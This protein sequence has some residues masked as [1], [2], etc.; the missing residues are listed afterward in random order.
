MSGKSGVEDTWRATQ[1]STWDKSL[2]WHQITARKV[3]CGQLDTSTGYQ[4]CLSPTEPSHQEGVRQSGIRVVRPPSRCGHRRNSWSPHT[5][6]Y[7]LTKGRGQEPRN[8]CPTRLLGG[9]QTQAIRV[10]S[11]AKTFT[12]GDGC[13]ATRP[14]LRYPSEPGGTAAYRL[15]APPVCR[16]WPPA[17]AVQ[18]S[19]TGALRPLSPW[20]PPY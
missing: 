8:S 13:G 4:A 12:L 7:G 2:D 1:N 14:A 10:S 15:H 5:V 3:T 19:R 20:T 11:R 18:T 9:R 17:K 6:A 16:A